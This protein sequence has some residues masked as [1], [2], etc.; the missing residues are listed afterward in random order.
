MIEYSSSFVRIRVETSEFFHWPRRSTNHKAGWKTLRMAT[1]RDRLGFTVTVARAQTCNVLCEIWTLEDWAEIC[2]A[3]V[4]RA[5]RRWSTPLS[6][7]TFRRY[8]CWKCSNMG[9]PVCQWKW[10]GSS[11][12]EYSSSLSFPIVSGWCWEN[13]SMITPFRWSTFSPCRS[14]ERVSASKQSILSFK[15]KCSTCWN[16]PVDRR[17]S[18]AG[19]I[20]TRVSAVG[21]PVSTSTRNKVSKRWPNAQW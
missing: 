10:W 8:P 13:S 17:W 12:L 15:R 4:L 16:K 18:S 7:C 9:V 20:L 14:P 21:C 2:R 19:T 5:I 1:R 3:V 6:R 11:T